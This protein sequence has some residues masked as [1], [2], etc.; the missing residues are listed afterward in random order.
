MSDASWQTT[1]Q[2]G[3]S[4]CTDSRLGPRTRDVAALAVAVVWLGC[5]AP[6]EA[7]Q[8]GADDGFQ[9][10]V[11]SGQT[12]TV[13]HGYNDP[14]AG[15]TCVI[16]SGPDHC[17][18]QQFGLDLEPSDQGDTRVLSPTAGTVAWN[19]TEGSGCIGI[20]TGDGL[21]LTVC[22]LASPAISVG[23]PLD[24]GDELGTRSTSW[25]HLSLDDRSGPNPQAV[26]F[27]GAH[28][29]EGLEF[30]PTGARNEFLGRAITS[31]NGALGQDSSNPG[32]VSW[33]PYD[34]VVSP[35]DAGWQDVV[36]GLALHNGTDQWYWWN[37]LRGPVPRDLGIAVGNTYEGTWDTDELD[38]GS[39]QTSAPIPPGGTI[40]GFS[41][42]PARFS[43]SGRIPESQVLTDVRLDNGDVVAMPA[44]PQASV[45]GI[46]PTGTPVGEWAT[47]STV[48]TGRVGLGE[49]DPDDEGG[50]ALSVRVKNDDGLAG[51]DVGV[52]GWIVSQ[53][54][55]YRSPSGTSCHLDRLD[56][57]PN[58]EIECSFWFPNE[59]DGDPSPLE[60]GPAVLGIIQVCPFDRHE[61]R[62]DCKGTYD[63]GDFVALNLSQ[64]GAGPSGSTDA[65]GSLR[66]LLS[67][68][69]AESC[70][71][72]DAG[73]GGV[74]EEALLCEP[75]L[76]AVDKIYLIRYP[77]QA[78]LSEAGRDATL[79]YVYD[80]L[81]RDERDGACFDGDEGVDDNIHEPT[82]AW[83]LVACWF[84]DGEARLYWI[85]ED[86]LVEGMVTAPSGI[87]KAARWLAKNYPSN[88]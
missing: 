33:V 41:P 69:L 70:S 11:A 76:P 83:T 25:I 6:A 1:W 34:L 14:I 47:L 49:F 45:C 10:P 22:H 57:G 44:T 50:A 13:I 37:E 26:P 32:V 42:R 35:G 58:Q 63:Q 20:A 64:P 88:P 78:T 77:D 12:L 65:S 55:V 84:K 24:T 7:A 60:L 15:E 40:C 71:P 86:H 67:P 61:N 54:G 87:R 16:G 73:M 3:R 85:D 46:T 17:E 80:L 74:E 30:S 8:G 9:A 4:L 31:T 82:R 39:G 68:R 59:V 38:R 51:M 53:T 75:S 5:L 66:D 72:Y 36:A 29:I 81:G 52:R 18:N 2:R 56:I 62:A 79:A 27:V 28:R 23:T 48:G 43:L 19:D 21:N